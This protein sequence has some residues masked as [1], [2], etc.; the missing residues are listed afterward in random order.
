MVEHSHIR[1]LVARK[2]HSP[3]PVTSTWAAMAHNV[4]ATTASSR[5]NSLEEYRSEETHGLLTGLQVDSEPATRSTWSRRRIA[6][7]GAG[8][9]FLIL[10]ASFIPPLA[11]TTGGLYTD[12]EI[13]RSNGTHDFKKTALIV[14]IDG[15][16]CVV[17]ACITNLACS[18][19]YR[20]SYLDRGLTPHLLEI[21][22]KGLRAKYMQP[23]FPVRA[24]L[25]HKGCNIF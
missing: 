24:A 12:G 1:H 17:V 22:K 18:V 25:H 21:S 19:G 15:L 11:R 23:I 16:R 9:I 20:A 6:A 3:C 13:V 10:G 5:R 4:K 2:T 7:L 8:F 14:S